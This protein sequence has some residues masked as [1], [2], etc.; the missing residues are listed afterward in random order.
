MNRKHLSLLALILA[1]VLACA[2]LSAFAE[3]YSS[4]ALTLKNP[5]ITYGGQTCTAEI[6]LTLDGGVDM[7]NGAGRL[8]LSLMGGD[9]TALSGG[10]NWDGE[11]II[12]GL[13]GM[14]KSVKLP[15]LM[16]TDELSS[17]FGDMQESLAALEPQITALADAFNALMSYVP[18]QDVVSQAGEL[19]T[20]ALNIKYTADTRVEYIDGTELT[21]EFYDFSTTYDD[22]VKLLADCRALDPELDTLIGNL[23]TA[24]SDLIT[25]A[26][27]DTEVTE[28]EKAA[29]F[30]V[31]GYV[32]TTEN[33]DFA[34]SYSLSES[35]DSE[36]FAF[37]QTVVFNNE[38]DTHVNVYAE[39]PGDSSEKNYLI[40]DAVIPKEDGDVTISLYMDNIEENG[41]SEGEGFQ[42][43]FITNAAARSISLSFTCFEDYLYEDELCEDT[44]DYTLTYLAGD[45]VTDETGTTYPGKLVLEINQDGE[46]ITVGLE[47]ELRLYASDQTFAASDDVIDL[48]DPDSNE[49]DALT[50]EFFSVYNSAAAIIAAAPGMADLLSFLGV[51]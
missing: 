35:A 43:L 25:A 39:L 15:L 46:T 9:Q 8:L 34:F 18:S 11:S 49:M 33:G 6:A 41:T 26:D 17:G 31:S 45:T 27:I 40:A 19:A 29:A 30:A 10:A 32:L 38:A 4:A 44:V 42:L 16:L 50:S 48:S 51:Q 36:E 2:P 22:I 23:E 47:T 13:D 14:T 7:E 12:A 21:G 3:S 28:S 24:I 20:A 1:L 37:F 5:S